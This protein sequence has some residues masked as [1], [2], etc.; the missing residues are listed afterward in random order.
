M[1]VLKSGA[2]LRAAEIGL[3]AT[4]GCVSDIAVTKKTDKKVTI[5][6]L[7]TGNELVPAST[8][9]LP[10]GKI[11]DSN[12]RM[13]RAIAEA[14]PRAFVVDL[15]TVGDTGDQIDEAFKQAIEQS[16]CDV[17]ISSGGVSMGELDLIKPYVELKGQIYFGRLNMKPGKPTTFGQI[18]NCLVLALPGNPVSC[19]VTASLFLPS[20]VKTL[21]TG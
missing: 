16:A 17:I 7:S 4:V 15:G 1:L 12:K 2:T 21:L 14:I 13:L 3:L 19:Y 6:I 11:R 8:K 10:P 9:D 5:G 20:I 18:G